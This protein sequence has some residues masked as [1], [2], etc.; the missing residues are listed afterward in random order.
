MLLL[1]DEFSTVTGEWVCIYLT[2]QSLRSRHERPVLES[3]VNQRLLQASSYLEDDSLQREVARAGTGLIL[4]HNDTFTSAIVPPFPVTADSVAVGT[5]N[6]EP[7]RHVLE[8]PRRLLLVLVTWN[9]YVLALF[10]SETLVRYKKG[11]GHIHAPHKKGGSSQARFARRT[12]NQRA[13]FLQRVGSHIDELLG[14]ES[15]DHVCFGGNRLILEPLTRHS[16]FL[17]DHRAVLSPRVLL[18]KKATL[19]SL[20]GALTDANSTVLL[21]P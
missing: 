17:R 7:L 10:D 15:V 12:Q 4:L 19:D 1:L 9:A 14:E 20:D 2:P 21:S 6:L 18:V 11:T 16:R 8:R 13:E 5:P 3:R